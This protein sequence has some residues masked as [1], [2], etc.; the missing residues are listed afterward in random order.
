MPA[1]DFSARRKNLNAIRTSLMGLLGVP[2]FYE[3][4]R[5]DLEAKGTVDSILEDEVINIF[6]N[7]RDTEFLDTHGFRQEH[8]LSQGNP[9]KV[10]YS[11]LLFE[12][13]PLGNVLRV[14][15]DNLKQPLDINEGMKMELGSTAKLRTLAHYL[16]LVASLYSDKK[17]IENS[18]NLIRDPITL[19]VVETLKE[20][21]QVS[22]DRLLEDSLDRTYSASPYEGS[23]QAGGSI[24]S[25]ILIPRTTTVE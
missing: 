10:I 15:T 7:L 19:W 8:L 23:S 14:Q 17:N 22:L 5:L 13:A 18:T 21:P 25:I 11:L 1:P 16:E 3:L 4:D 2:S 9:E 12:K 20:H 6:D 24:H